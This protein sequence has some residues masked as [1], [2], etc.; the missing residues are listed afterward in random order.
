MPVILVLER[1]SQEDQEFKASVGYRTKCEASLNYKGPCFKNG[2]KATRQQNSQYIDFPKVPH[3]YKTFLLSLA[4]L[5]ASLRKDRLDL[6]TMFSY[7]F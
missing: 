6:Y 3:L 2:N 7:G 1:Q 4:F 5:G